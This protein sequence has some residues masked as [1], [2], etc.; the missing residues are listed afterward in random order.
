[1]APT[2]GRPHSLL[3]SRRTR[4]CDRVLRRSGRA[5]RPVRRVLFRSSR[6]LD[7]HLPRRHVAVPLQQPTRGLGGPRRRP[8]SGLAP[9]EVYLA[10]HV[11]MSPGGL[12]HHPFTLTAT[13]GRR[14]SSLCGTVSR[15]SPGGCYPPPCPVEPGRSSVRSP[16]TRPS[17][18]P[19]RRPILPGRASL[20]RVGADVQ[21]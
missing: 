12:L 14:R 21:V 13:L 9:G 6:S 1:P 3:D 19:A 15:I 16:A 11:T 20:P 5:G 10:G 8:L 18:R 7:G 2:P 4:S 17:S